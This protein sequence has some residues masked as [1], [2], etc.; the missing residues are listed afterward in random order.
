MGQRLFYEKPK[1]QPKHFN[2]HL[3]NE[4]SRPIMETTAAA[5]PTTTHSNT[6][7]IIRK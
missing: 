2:S 6:H 5:P 3:F 1:L 4:I 7:Q